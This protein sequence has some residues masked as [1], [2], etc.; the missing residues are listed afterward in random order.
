M[1]IPF[2]PEHFAFIISWVD[3]PELMFQYS[4]PDYPYPR[5]EERLAEYTET[6][7]DRDRFMYRHDGQVIGY[8]EVLYNGEFQPRLGRLLIGPKALRKKGHG[9]RMIRELI[10]Y[11]KRHDP[12]Q[13]VYLYVFTDNKNAIR[14]YT[15]VGFVKSRP[16]PKHLLELQKSARLMHFD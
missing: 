14:S 2:G 16:E 10:D 5:T 1:L 3:S 12:G 13:R 9:T 11:C 15:T 7:H 4:G 6:V 8:G